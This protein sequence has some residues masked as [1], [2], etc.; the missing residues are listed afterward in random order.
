MADVS[1]RLEREIA[2]QGTILAARASEG[3]VAATA[4]AETLRGCGHVVMAARGSSDNAA[5]FAQ[6]LFGDELRLQVGLAAPWLYRDVA[7][8]PRLDDAAVMAIS[9]SGQ[10]PD[11]VAVLVAARAQGR[12]TIAITN[13]PDSDLATQ[14]DVVVPLLIGHERSVAATKSYLASL[15]A[16][17][18]IVEGLSPSDARRDWLARLPA[19]VTAT[20]ASALARREEF[21]VLWGSSPITVTGR[22]LFFSTACETALKLR[23]LSGIPAEAFSPPDLMHGPIAALHHP[24][25]T[26]LINPGDELGAVAERIV[27]SVIV[28]ADQRALARARVPIELPVDLPHWF[29]S[30]LAVV[31]AQA[32]GLRLAERSGGDVDNPHGLQK[33]TLTS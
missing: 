6:Y 16:M 18:Q 23:E 3:M 28:S 11:I 17:V 9:Q 19:R 31:P 26:W 33:V 10:S 4:A 2:E 20:A 12:P 13:A 22:G 5:R 32:A 15:H 7:R 14:A 30:I 1:S 24:A 29:A 8:A 27:P 25:G 21:D